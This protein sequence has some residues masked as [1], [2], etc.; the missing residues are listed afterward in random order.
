MNENKCVDGALKARIIPEHTK[1]DFLRS[2]WIALANE[3]APIQ[4]FEGDFNEIAE[5]EHEVLIDH[6]SVDVSY[7]VSV[8]YDRKEPYIA[9]ETYYE[10]EPYITTES[11]YDRNTNSTRTREVTKYKKVQRQRQVTRYKT[12]TDWSALNGS[13]QATS[14]ATVENLP[15]QYLDEDL[16]TS[17]FVTKTSDSTVLIDV[18]ENAEIKLNEAAYEAAMEEHRSK[19]Y[20]S[21]YRSLPGDHS[22]DLDYQIKEIISHDSTIYKTC[23]YEASIYYNGKSYTK[24]AFPF[25][26]MNVGGD[27]IENPISPENAAQEMKKE[28]NDKIASRNHEITENIWKSTKI[29]SLIGVLLLCLSIAGSVFVRST[30]VVISLFAVAGAY[31]IFNQIFVKR[32]DARE[33]E[34]AKNEIKQICESTKYEI[35]NYASNYKSRQKIALNKKLKSLGL[36]PVGAEELEAV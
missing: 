18:E 28:M 23:E 3:D 29:V 11:Y 20:S 32:A 1:E 17:S 35:E 19:I 14:I 34:R 8:G 33:L 10:D 9:Y 36:K 2:A 4:V 27:R 13:H 25:G 12:V 31:F 24:K 22:R 15:G 21:L 30:V 7:Q 16:F 6:I 26:T 5:S